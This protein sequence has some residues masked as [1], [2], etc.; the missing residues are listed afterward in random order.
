MIVGLICWIGMIFQTNGLEN[1][2]F[3]TSLAEL[4]F[5]PRSNAW[6]LS[7]RLFTDDLEAGLSNHYKKNLKLDNDNQGDAY[8]PDYIAK[9]FGF[10]EGDKLVHPFQYLGYQVETEV[11]WVYA[12]WPNGGNLTGK[13]LENTLLLELF[14]NQM[15]IV[16]L[17]NQGKKSSMIFKKEKKITTLE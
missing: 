10:R 13:K 5:N 6:E 16:H 11:T 8:I 4:H 2:P 3:H 1:H 12:E 9:H 15:N 17:E 14:D 7:I